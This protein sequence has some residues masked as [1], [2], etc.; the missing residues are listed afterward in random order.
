M[1]FAKTKRIR[2]PNFSEKEKKLLL[3]LIYD[4]RTIFENCDLSSAVHHQKKQA[5]LEVAAQFNKLRPAGTIRS[6]N[7]IRILYDNLKNRVRRREKIRQNGTSNSCFIK[8]GAATTQTEFENE[9]FLNSESVSKFPN[10]SDISK[11]VDIV[12]SVSTFSLI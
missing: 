10:N 11:A 12:V 5:W 1:S 9:S 2:S 6:A 3:K 4:R 7:S 8:P